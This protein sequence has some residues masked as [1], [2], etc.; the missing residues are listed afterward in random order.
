MENTTVITGGGCFRA[1]TLV[2]LDMGKTIPIE[3]IKEG[4]EILAFDENGEVHLAKV[5]IVHY[6]KDPE[7]LLKVK[8]WNGEIF[9][10]PNHWVLNQYDAFAEMSRLTTH[11]ALVD[12]MGHLRPIISME[13][14]DSEPVWNLTVEPYHTFIANGIRVHNGGFRERFP[15]AGGG[16]GKS[17][18]RQKPPKEDPDTL[19]SRQYARIV[20]LISEGEIVGLA[21]GWKSI[22]LDN[23]PLQSEDGTVNFSGISVYANSGIQWQDYLPGFSAVEAEHA[24]GVEVIKNIPVVR[25]LSNTNADAARI[26][27]SIPNLSRIVTETVSST[28]TIVGVWPNSAWVSTPG[29]NAGDV[30]GSSVTISIEVNN[31][32]GG[33]VPAKLN[34]VHNTLWYDGIYASTEPYAL[35]LSAARLYFAWT[36]V[37]PTETIYGGGEDGSFSI[38]SN[39]EQAATYIIQYRQLP[40]GTWTTFKSG[41][42]RNT[43]VPIRGTTSEGGW[44]DG[45]I[46]GYTTPSQEV[47]A[48]VL[49]L[50]YSGYEFRAVKTSG[51]GS[52]TCT[53]AQGLGW[54]STDTITGKTTS[55][56]QKAY[57][58]PLDQPGPWEIRVTRITDDSTKS[59]LQNQTWWDSYTEIVDAKLRYPNSA[60]VAISLDA[61]QFS[62]VPTRGYEIYGLKVRYPSNYNPYTRTYTGS[63]DGNF[64]YGWTDNPAWCFYDLVTNERY[65]LG[66]FI[67]SNQVDKWALYTIAKYCDEMVPNGFNGYE[68]RFTC[69]L[70]L[71]TREEAYN[72]INSMA[73]IFRGMLYWANGSI[74]PVQDAPMDPVALFTPAN[75]V[76]GSFTYEGSS[77]KSRH[78]VALVSWNDPSDMY[79]QKIEYVEDPDAVAKYGLVETEILAVGCTSRGQAHRL[80]KWLIYSE[81]HE[82]EVVRFKT[83][84]DGLVINPGDIIN[85]TDP[86]RAGDRLG[87]RVVIATTSQVTIDTTITIESGRTYTLWVTLPDGTVKAKPVVNSPGQTNTILLSTVP[88]P[89]PERPLTH[90]IWVLAADNLIPQSWKVISVT[91]ADQ[92]TAEITALAHRP[93]KFDHVENDLFLAELPVNG[94]SIIPEAPVSGVLSDAIYFNG[95]SVLTRLLLS[96]E[97]NATAFKYRV[98]F[99]RVGE[100]WVENYTTTSSSSIDIPNVSDGSEYQVRVWAVNAIGNKS[101]TALEL[102]HVALGKYAPPS[103]VPSIFSQVNLDG[104][105]LAWDDILDID[106]FDFGLC[107]TTDWTGPVTWVSGTSYYLPPQI[108][109]NHTISIKARD[110]TENVSTNPT[111]ANF[112]VL[113]P[114]FPTVNTF[115]TDGKLTA[116]WNNCQTSHQVIRYDVRL[117]G[118]TWNEAVP[119]ASLNAQTI[120]ITPDWMG[121][122][123]IRVKAVDIAGNVSQ[124]GA[125]LIDVIEASAPVLDADIV[126][127]DLLLSWTCEQGSLPIISYEIRWGASWAT[128]KYITRISATSFK[129]RVDWAGGRTWWVAAVDS[130]NNFGAPA[131]ILSTIQV[132]GTPTISYAFEATATRLQWDSVK[133]TLDIDVYEIIRGATPA[134]GVLLGTSYTTTFSV[135]VDW[136][137]SATFWIRAK[138]TAGN[139]GA[140]GSSI[141]GVTAPTTPQIGFIFSGEDCILKWDATLVVPNSLPVAGYEVRFGS[142]WE[143]GVLVGKTTDSSVRT[144]ASWLGT[145]IFHLKTFNSAGTYGALTSVDVTIGTYEAPTGLS[146]V[147]SLTDLVLTWASATGGQTPISYYEVR[148]GDIWELGVTVGKTSG[149][150]I[151]IPINWPIPQGDQ[152][153]TRT[154]WV[155]A[156]DVF[157]GVGVPESVSHVI[158]RPGSVNVSHSIVAVKAQLSW[159]PPTSSLP[160]AYYDIRYT[161]PSTP[162][163][164]WENATPIT[165]QNGTDYRVSIDWVGDRTFW[166][167]AVDVNGNIGNSGSTF[168][169]ISAPQQPTVAAHV[170]LDTFVLTWSTPSSTIPITDYEIRYND[171]AVSNFATSIEYGHS[172]TNTISVKGEWAGDRTFWISAIDVNGNKGPAGSTTA[173]ILAANAP[174]GY[175][176]EVVD[177]N[178]LLY[179]NQVQGTMP[180]VTYEL[181]KGE[182]WETAGG[183]GQKSGGF[184]TIF[185]TSAGIF[186]YWIAAVDSAGNIGTPTSLVCVVNTPPDYVLKLNYESTFTGT[187]VNAKSEGTALLLPVNTTET[188]QEHFNNNSWANPQA[189]VNA[190]YPI[191]LQPTP[192]TASYTETYDYGTILSAN[193][194]TLTV[195]STIIAGAVTLSSTISASVDGTNWTDYVGVFQTYATNFR[196]VKFTLN[197][198][199]STSAGLMRI[200]GIN[201]RLDSKLK[202]ITSTIKCI[203]PVNGTYGQ[204]GTPTLTVSATGTWLAGQYVDMNFTSGTAANGIYRITTGGTD[205]FTLTMGTNLT[206]SGNVTID[207]DGTVMYITETGLHT[208]QK[209]FVDVDAI[210]IS[211]SGTTPQIALYNFTDTA[212]PLYLKGLL[213]NTSGTRVGGLASVTVRG[214]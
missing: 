169:D 163:P 126:G 128:A 182:A 154:F 59:T 95:A 69:N 90:S 64:S 85:T 148:Y 123:T 149:N 87:G 180:T 53:N 2:Q 131:S 74:V 161:T 185:E 193:K 31:N 115:F 50:P 49:N 79:K 62:S 41:E 176:Q 146:L 124:E 168:V 136:D 28:K 71:Q 181:R 24:V 178:V 23:T 92:Q 152:S 10:T 76:E 12:G 30:K 198:T 110:T 171:T 145:R 141:V 58:I 46:I 43:S 112:T 52:F 34:Y 151:T 133:T 55:K 57:R 11:D 104:V 155:N 210:Q 94:I 70:F 8:F 147:Q 111:L 122:N 192:L 135:P 134:L 118:P 164:S 6:H 84:L 47:Y 40:G 67:D 213:F 109:G 39:L 113:A 202:T 25:T 132:P 188:Y 72:V 89:L 101:N 196:Y 27:I 183:L 208:G 108:A 42:V 127:P 17:G 174:T 54:S 125:T 105:Y 48:E 156:V 37:A 184:T 166:V 93:D 88:E 209:V 80:G 129:Y 96:W 29:E 121:D 60:L 197:A 117:G 173:T 189:Q 162:S 153:V 32:G 18:G 138:D 142:T 100:N 98:D 114:L 14:V 5:S 78:T 177:N 137:T 167:A 66:K 211:A 73:S 51:T 86:V 170:S 35:A 102:S 61:E 207:G 187:K 20:D 7:P 140:Y 130:A 56:Y 139:Y 179:W 150:T 205:T 200:N 91:E 212:N 26:T 120:T 68:P 119:I 190:G 33:F 16:G 194:I 160:I 191:Y 21:N 1:G 206:T 106:R 214:F 201:L 36:G 45:P 144:P 97:H 195:N 44:L 19:R 103:D 204:T 157:D 81:K 75:V 99:R 158:N 159:L 63:W 38:Y 116:T 175:R 199:A 13:S 107:T 22:Y 77:L 15:I 186:T 143:T 83:G 4:D 172:N 3:Q 9:I 82:S 65:G 165:V 203:A